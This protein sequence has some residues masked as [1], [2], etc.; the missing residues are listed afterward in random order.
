MGRVYW[1]A[2]SPL[3]LLP[4]SSRA[5]RIRL[6]YNRLAPRLPV[7][8][9]APANGGSTGH[10]RGRSDPRQTDGR[11]HCRPHRAAIIMLGQP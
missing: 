2:V 11:L 6:E 3:G 10:K 4:S 7:H 9:A 8:T 1:D 5:S